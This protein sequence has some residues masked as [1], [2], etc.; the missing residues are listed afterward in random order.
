VILY[1][2][3]NS[4]AVKLD[5][6]TIELYSL[7]K[8][9]TKIIDECSVKKPATNSDPASCKSNGVLLVSASIEIKKNINTGNKGAI[10][11]IDC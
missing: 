8:K 7:K 2:P 5:I 9:N 10:Y 1:P 4:I 3:K 11:Q 6:N